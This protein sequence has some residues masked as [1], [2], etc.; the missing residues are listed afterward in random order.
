MEQLDVPWMLTREIIPV[1]PPSGG[2]APRM[3]LAT[4]ASARESCNLA[5]RT[6]SVPFTEL[7]GAPSFKFKLPAED[8]RIVASQ[9]AASRVGGFVPQR[10]FVAKKPLQSKLRLRCPS[11]AATLLALHPLRVCAI[12][13]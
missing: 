9:P 3:S 8:E 5:R 12:I 2:T 7:L 10:Q 4:Q 11:Q 6:L 13:C 1:F